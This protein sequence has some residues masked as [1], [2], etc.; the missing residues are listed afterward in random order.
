MVVEIVDLEPARQGQG[1]V[2]EESV[3]TEAGDVAGDGDQ[4]HVDGLIT[5]TARVLAALG[6]IEPS[7]RVSTTASPTTS[8]S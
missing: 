8:A 6:E 4:E 1:V 2:D 7:R 3:E 5:P